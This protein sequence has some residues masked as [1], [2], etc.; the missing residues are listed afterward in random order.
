[1]A[2]VRSRR[3]DASSAKS[4]ERRAKSEER[5]QT[6]PTNA[7]NQLPSRS[8]RANLTSPA[9][10]ASCKFTH[11]MAGFCW[12]Q[13]GIHGGHQWHKQLR[14]SSPSSIQPILG[15]YADRMPAFRMEWRSSIW[16]RDN[17]TPAGF[18]GGSARSWPARLRPSETHRRRS[19]R[20]PG[21]AV[22]S[23]RRPNR[24]PKQGRGRRAPPASSCQEQPMTTCSSP[25]SRP[26]HARCLGRPRR[27]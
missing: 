9:A 17:R 25:I 27:P 18:I 8:S 12:A 6:A 16:R 15:S 4:E 14:S 13:Q 24:Q 11:S 10:T 20:R 22:L 23:S 7:Q 5:R 3:A 1:M 2:A 21:R 26:A 19:R